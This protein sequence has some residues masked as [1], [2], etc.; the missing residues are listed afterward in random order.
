MPADP[1]KHVIVLMMENHSFD[2]MLGSLKKVYS[3][4]DGIDPNDPG[5]NRDAG[6]K[7]YAQQVTKATKVLSDP[8]HALSNVLAQ[9]ENHNSGFVLDYLR[10]FPTADAQLVMDYYDVDFLPVLHTLAQNFAVCD[11]WFSSMPGPTWPNRFFVNTGTC[12]GHVLMP[13]GVF[14]PNIYRYNQATVFNRLSERGISWKIYHHGEMQTLVL[15][16]LWLHL[17][18]FCGMDDFLE[19]ARGPE[20]EFPQYCFI[21][22]DYSGPDQNDQH[23]PTDIM[24]GER[25]IGEVYNAIRQNEALWNSSLIVLIYDE[26]GGFYDHV[27]PGATV[28]PDN[29]TSEFDF[30]RFGLRVPALL[31]SPWIDT[32]VIKT[33]F[34][35]TSVLR[36]VQEKWSLGDLRDRTAHANSFGP[37]LLKRQTA[38]TD[39]PG[40]LQ[41]LP[42]PSPISMTAALA[43]PVQPNENQQALVAFSQYLETQM[44]SDTSKVGERTLRSLTAASQASVSKERFQD[45]LRRG[46]QSAPRR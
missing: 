29:L 10:A 1:I 45:F 9:I 36:Y 40:P 26:H 39:T 30:K 6:G 19:D 7:I 8:R 27:E 13:T 32:G 37:E 44:E 42:A 33:E 2:Q 4:L 34:D 25:L 41:N 11:R 14:D 3:N 38:R 24:Q 16:Q 22:P 18:H 5:V 31:I 20:S 46:P 17:T 15:S 28:P 23:P 43:A 12:M 35:H 21:E